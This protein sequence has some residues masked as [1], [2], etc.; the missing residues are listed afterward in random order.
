MLARVK[1]YLVALGALAAAVV[2]ALFLTRRNG[3]KEGREQAQMEA[4]KDAQE[5]TE[6]GREAVVRG[7]SAGTPDQRLRDND[8]KW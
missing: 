2:S 5:R 4:L 6:R 1:Y 7:R 3:R 8:G